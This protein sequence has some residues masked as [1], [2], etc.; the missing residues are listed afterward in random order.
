MLDLNKISKSISLIAKNI[1]EASEDS[2]MEQHIKNLK[3]TILA[4]ELY[5][6]A[7]MLSEE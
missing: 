1:I 2:N 4:S 7:D 6:V 5:G 3:I